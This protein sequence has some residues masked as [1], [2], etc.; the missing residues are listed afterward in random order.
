MDIELRGSGL[1][2]IDLTHLIRGKLDPSQTPDYGAAVPQL[3]IPILF[4]TAYGQRYRRNELLMAGADEIIQKPVDF[5]ELHTAMTR[6]Y[7]SRV[8][9]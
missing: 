4:V 9:R 1:N 5:V 8:Q 2:G 7:L 6:V 3:D